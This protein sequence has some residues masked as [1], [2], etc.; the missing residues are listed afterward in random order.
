MF[1]CTNTLLHAEAAVANRNRCSISIEAVYS[2]IDANT[3]P[4]PAWCCCSRTAEN[5]V[6]SAEHL[7]INTL[8]TAVSV[9]VWKADFDFP[10]VQNSYRRKENIPPSTGRLSKCSESS[11]WFRAHKQCHTSDLTFDT[12][13]TLCYCCPLASTPKTMGVKYS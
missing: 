9:A 13:V 8:K 11:H 7:S 12:V 6:G 4:H 10:V 5:H 3:G 1:K 2:G